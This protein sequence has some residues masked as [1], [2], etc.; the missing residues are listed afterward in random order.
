[1]RKVVPISIPEEMHKRLKHELKIR[2]GLHMS[3]FIRR[4]INKYFTEQDERK[5]LIKERAN[6]LLK[7]IIEKAKEDLYHPED[8]SPSPGSGLL[9]S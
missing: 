5:Y 3:E 4:L 6:Q 8:D 9:I 7:Q 2:G 1:M